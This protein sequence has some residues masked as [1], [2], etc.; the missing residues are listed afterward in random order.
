M[1]TDIG[2]IGD[3]DYVKQDKELDEI[4]QELYG[5]KDANGNVKSMQDTITNSIDDINP[6][7]KKFAC[8]DVPFKEAFLEE[9][10]IVEYLLHI[11]HYFMIMFQMLMAKVMLNNCIHIMKHL[12]NVH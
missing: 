10:D 1:R 9:S 5:G 11:Q 4:H 2:N 3:I 6:F 8:S 12:V 7:I